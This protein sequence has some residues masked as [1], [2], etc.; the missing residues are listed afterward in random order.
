VNPH[1]LFNALNNIY[2]LENKKSPD[3][4]PAIL[5]LSELIRYMLYETQPEFVML[6]KELNYLENYVELQKLGLSSKIQI[7]FEITGISGDKKIQPMLLLPLVENI[8]KH[9]ISYLNESLLSIRINIEPDTLSIS[10]Q[11]PVPNPSPARSGNSGIGLSNLRKRLD[12][13]YPRKH[14]LIISEQD[15]IFSTHLTLQLK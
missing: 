3:T 6:D 13:L 5:K 4:G 10:T 14:E 2:S 12:L 9:G 8:F 7:V 15:G 1:F 11:N